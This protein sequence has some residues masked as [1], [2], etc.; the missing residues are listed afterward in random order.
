[1]SNQHQHP[2]KITTTLKLLALTASVPWAMDVQAQDASTYYTV[3]N[4]Q[5]FKTDWTGFYRSADAATAA[6]RSQF[7]H[8]LDLSYGPDIK[9]RLDLY[10]PSNNPV[11]AP[12]FLFL[13]GGGFREG[14]RAQYGFIARP[15]VEKGIIVAVAS[16]RLTDPGFIYPHQP[17]DTR[18]ALQWLYQNVKAHGGDNLQLFIGGHSA[19]G[20]L[21]ADVGVNRA[22][23]AAARIPKEA[24]RG[25]VPVSGIYDLRVSD[26]A[27]KVFWRTYASNSAQQHA[28]SPIL[29]IT[30]PVPKAVVAVGSTEQLGDEDFV[31]SSKT[32][33]EKLE[34]AGVKTQFLSLD[35]MAHKDTAEALGDPSSPLAQAAVS[36]I[37][38]A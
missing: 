14:D 25:I 17:E 28:A 31:G 13:H 3:K 6:L 16:Y 37:L 32:L 7:P 19:G 38:G 2:R 23:M 5:L 20:L 12:V 1:M 27:A 10:R 21:A 26:P 4:P 18:L 33:A 36:M 8:V 35:G 34:G 9:Q 30:D 11:G 22:W 29:H 24:L 15:F